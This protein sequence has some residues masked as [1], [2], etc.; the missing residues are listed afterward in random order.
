MISKTKKE[1]H[2]SLSTL[3]IETRPNGD[4]L[5]I[6]IYNGEDCIHFANWREWYYFCEQ[7]NSEKR[8]QKF[9]AH[10]GGKFDWVS[11][12]EF[13]LEDL[14]KV[15]IIIQGSQIVFVK[16]EDFEK[17]IVLQDSVLVIRSSLKNLCETFKI[18]TPKK[19]I[20]IT[21]IEEIFENDYETYK[22]YLERDCISLFQVIEKAEELFEIDYWPVTIA[23]LSMYKFRREFL[24]DNLFNPKLGNGG[25][26]DAFFSESYAG[27]RVE[28][29]K[30]GLYDRVYVYDVNSLYPSVMVS[31]EIPISLPYKTY[32][33]SIKQCGFYR[34]EFKQ[35]NKELPPVLW[36]KTKNGLEFVYEGVGVFYYQEINL[37]KQVGGDIK[38]IE[39]YIFPKT[40]KVFTKFVEFFYGTRLKNY[41]NKALNFCYKIIL[42]SLYGKFAQKNKT[43][44]LVKW[45]CETFLENKDKVKWEP[46][47]ESKGIYQIEEETT[48]PHRI[49]YVSSII[50]ALA[51]IA[52]YKYF[53]LRPNDLIYCDTDSVHTLSPIPKKYLDSQKLGFLKLE[54]EGERG[55]YI[56]RKQYA[57]G[58]KL[59]FKGIPLKSNLK[60]DDLTFDDY[61]NLLYNGTRE[62]NYKSF[63]SLK[64]VL[65]R[66]KKACAQVDLKRNMKMADYQTN[67]RKEK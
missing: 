7:N 5:S 45:D 18:E 24:E 60:H 20:D 35:Y 23:S 27:G 63:P 56:G 32:T 49:V 57:I 9:V 66:N 47:I 53:L 41:D 50:T 36:E 33:Y 13:L 15:E 22:E 12:I 17:R 52:L 64:T 43:T 54:N 61:V 37:L 6:C 59:K 29:F 46:Y 2:N 30:P 14:K 62:F 16:I 67:F 11:L 1:Y 51:R 39:G 31:A 3:D 19:E 65:K 21:K 26:L 42:N 10:N 48:V 34:V 38:V 8:Y 28:C 4:V 40:K 25:K 55:C 44:K 58:K